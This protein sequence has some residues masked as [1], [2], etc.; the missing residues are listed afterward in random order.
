MEP[1]ATKPANPFHELAIMPKALKILGLGF[2]V[3]GSKKTTKKS[4]NPKTLNDHQ[5]S[6]NPGIPYKGA[7]KQK[8][9]TWRPF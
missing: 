3:L 7:S 1:V 6:P 8:P 2:R 9:A 5:E 4:L